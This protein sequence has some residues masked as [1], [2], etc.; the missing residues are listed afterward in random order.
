MILPETADTRNT[1]SK[2][3]YMLVSPAIVPAIERVGWY[4]YNALVSSDHRAGFIDFNTTKL[5]HN[6][7]TNI[8]HPSIR[9][10]RLHTPNRVEKYLQAM[11]YLFDTRQLLPAVTELEEIA[12][13]QGWSKELEQKYNNID[14]EMTNIMIR[15]EKDCA[16]SQNTKNPWSTQLKEKGLIYRYWNL[17]LRQLDDLPVSQVQITSLRHFLNLQDITTEQTQVIIQKK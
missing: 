15:A 13:E 3:D 17:R 7:I 4:E 16:P 5:F 6:G 9:K 1:G 12:R 8:T 10:L 11:C 14:R 2:I